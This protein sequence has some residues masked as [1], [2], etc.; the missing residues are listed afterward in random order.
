[1][2]I[3]WP[4]REHSIKF[5]GDVRRYQLN[6]NLDRLYRPQVVFGSGLLVSGRLKP[7]NNGPDEVIQKGPP[8]PTSGV[9]LPSLGRA[10][11]ILQTVTRDVPDSTIGLRFTEYHLFFNDNWRVH[12]GLTI[13]YGLRWEHS[14]VPHDVNNRIE[15]HLAL[16]DLPEAGKSRFDSADR[17]NRFLAAVAAYKH[18]LDRP[19]ADH[20]PGD[21][22][23]C[24]P[25]TGG[26]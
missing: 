20:D 5:G 2:T 12:P 6:S 24:P 10:S 19:T 18:P 25:A 11:S 15:D 14:T 3:S 7:T 16:K 8:V 23:T 9:E 21:N 4:V 13:D 22:D 26:A 1:D 17:T